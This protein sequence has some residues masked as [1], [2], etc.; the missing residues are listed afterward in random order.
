MKDLWEFAADLEDY[1][2]KLAQAQV[3]LD[4]QR[5]ACA[6]IMA[7]VAELGSIGFAARAVHDAPG[8]TFVLTCDVLLETTQ[9]AERDRPIEVVAAEVIP[10]GPPAVVIECEPTGE[11]PVVIEPAPVAEAPVLAEVPCEATEAP[12][13]KPSRGPQTGAI[14]T[15]TE[16]AKAVQIFVAAR[17]KGITRTDAAQLVADAL[18]RPFQGVE[19][20]LKTKLAAAVHAANAEAETIIAPVQ[21]DKTCHVDAPPTTLASIASDPLRHHLLGLRRLGKHKID[22]DL[23]M[24]ESICDGLE[25][26]VIADQIGIDVAEVKRRFDALTGFYRDDD[27]KPRRKWSREQVL[28]TLRAL[29]QVTGRGAAT[30]AK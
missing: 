6:I 16:D 17:A 1:G 7:A 8:Q 27:S 10:A 25:A 21:V 28:M 30:A 29:L 2:Q 14:W 18:D 19:Y 9:A 15:Q 3:R 4:R 12:E 22:D 24:M 20:R 13:A 26:T 11:M 5:D 23:E